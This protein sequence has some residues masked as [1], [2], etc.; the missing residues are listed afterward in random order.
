LSKADDAQV[1]GLV[2]RTNDAVPAEKDWVSLEG[3]RA[4]L[5]KKVRLSPL[6]G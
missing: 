6:A 2:R 1:I 5:A 3:F 4:R